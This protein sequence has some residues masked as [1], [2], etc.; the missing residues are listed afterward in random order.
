MDVIEAHV[1][2]GATGIVLRTPDYV[3]ALKKVAS[4]A[5]AAGKKV[6][7]WD[8]CGGIQEVLPEQEIT[9]Y[10]YA[11]RA[12]EMPPA[13]ALRAVLEKENA[14]TVLVDFHP[15]LNS[16][17]IISA[18]RSALVQSVSKGIILLFL[19]RT[20]AVPPDLEREMVILDCGLPGRED[21]EPVLRE[22]CRVAKYEPTGEEIKDAVDAALGLTM[23]EAEDA[24]AVELVR[25]RKLSPAG[26][27][28]QKR[29]IVERAGALD[30]VEGVPGLES[31]GGMDRLKAWLLKR[32]LTFSP[33]ALSY[34]LRPARG[35]LLLG[36]PGTGKS[37]TAKAVAGEWKKPLLRLD[38]GKVFGSY[39][40]ESEGNL[41]R[42]LKTVETVAPCVVWLDEV[43]K[44]FSGVASSGKTDSGVAA[45]VFGTFLT[46]MQEKTCPAFVVATA[47]DVS[48]LPPEFLRRGRFDEVFFIDLPDKWEREQILSIHLAKRNRDPGKYPLGELALSLEGYS[49]AEIEALVEEALLRAFSAG[50][51]L[52]SEDLAEAKTEVVP[53]SVIRKDEIERLREWARAYGLKPARSETATVKHERRIV[54]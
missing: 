28:A 19:S 37:L 49:G 54:T 38:V 46:W 45:R 40:G 32:L 48:A 8:A 30:F 50:R 23:K 44:G 51:E 21:L 16:P 9:C 20:F 1:R 34:G 13:N 42:A 6:F 31:V 24:F 4:A 7:I 14:V 36:V 18:V 25:N 29:Q 47:N 22:V 5:R 10:P 41:R 52:A 53:L 15:Y 26:V 3:F 12:K 17:G 33:E 2:A 39:V 27:F 11:E 43:E 35:C